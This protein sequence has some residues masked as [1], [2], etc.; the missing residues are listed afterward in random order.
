MLDLKIGEAIAILKGKKKKLV[1]FF[2]PIL[3]ILF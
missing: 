1:F 2:G 3:Y